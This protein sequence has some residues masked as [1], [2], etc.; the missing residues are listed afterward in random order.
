MT[1]SFELAPSV[2]AGDLADLAS[3]A[4]IGEAGG[5]DL[6]HVDVMDGHFVPNLTIGP[7]V[8][9]ALKAKTRLP[10]D[11]HLMVANPDRLLGAYLDAGAAR[12]SVHY[13]AA[14]HLDRLLA[15]I[16]ERGVSPGV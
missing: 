15:A 3:V 1:P 7:P 8:V 4:R 12:I 13:E 5:A 2:I 6:L 10:L 11:V 9:A 14:V 16:R